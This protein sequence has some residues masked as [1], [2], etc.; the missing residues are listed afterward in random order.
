MTL[1]NLTS[2]PVPFWES[3]CRLA[4][5]AIG[6]ICIQTNA[7]AAAEILNCLDYW[8]VT[9]TPSGSELGAPCAW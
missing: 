7:L 4:K 5:P 3:C 9:W 8:N 2:I 1:T 6:D